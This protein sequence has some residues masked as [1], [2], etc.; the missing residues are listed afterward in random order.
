MTEWSK[1]RVGRKAVCIRCKERHGERACHIDENG[2]DWREVRRAGE[3]F[4]RWV[5][6]YREGVR[7]RA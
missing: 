7:R 2:V 6:E 1:K 3:E 4:Y 5:V